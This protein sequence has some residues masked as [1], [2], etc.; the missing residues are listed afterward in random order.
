MVLLGNALLGSA[1][2]NRPGFLTILFCVKSNLYSKIRQQPEIN[3][4]K[5]RNMNEQIKRK[6]FH[7]TWKKTGINLHDFDILTSI[8][9]QS[10]QGVVFK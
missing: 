6:I 7:F 5:N 4:A 10:F 8:I 3:F 9:G 2:M 1:H